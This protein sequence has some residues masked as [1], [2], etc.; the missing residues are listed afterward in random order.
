MCSSDLHYD[1][2]CSNIHRGIHWLSERAT[3]A[4]ESTREKV[5]SLI[6]AEST[7][8][9]VFTSG[10]TS[11]PKGAVTTHGNIA[12]QISTLM[13][14]WAW[15]SEDVIPLFLPLHHVHG[16]INGLCSALAV[17]ATAEILPAFERSPFRSRESR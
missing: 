3:E 10:T 4:Y 16:I 7:E 6:N 11:K 9:I 13:D 1:E 12:A 2:E 8:N 14:A 15:Q 17:Q 5:R